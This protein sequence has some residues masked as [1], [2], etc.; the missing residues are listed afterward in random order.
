MTR[1]LLKPGQTIGVMAPSS[2]VPKDDI[3][4]SA[5]VMEARGF[6]VF[7]HPQTFEREN[8]SAGT[9]LQK[10]LAL[11]GLWQRADIDAV[12]CAGGGNRAMHMVEAI[13]F[14]KMQDKPKALIGFSD[15]TALINAVY[16]H[17][18]MVTYHGQVFKNLHRMEGA[19]LDYL[20]AVL[21]G[22]EHSFP[23]D[24]AIV[25][26]EGRAEGPLIG[27][28][29]SLFQYLPQILPGEFWKQGILF[30]EDCNEELS[31]IDRMFC[32][33]RQ[34]GVLRDIAGLVL[35]RFDP[36]PESGTPF[37]YRLEDILLEHTEGLDIPVVM[38]APFG[39]GSPLYALPVGQKAR[40]DAG[41]GG[42][43]RL[44]F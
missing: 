24:D 23:L 18:G 19:E 30:L 10:S 12:W 37:G 11:Q 16:A 3:E 15:A 22:G 4:Q 14:S 27:G 44:D 6:K 32:F 17:T 39:H 33:L 7:I 13:N 36:M 38:Q 5:A 26:R 2:H 42:R 43:V 31:R 1:P 29:L 25:L 40:L 8:Q 21:A 9:V 41:G 28:N 35:G 34:S 20:L